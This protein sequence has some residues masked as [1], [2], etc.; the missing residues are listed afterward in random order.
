MP[1][2]CTH[3]FARLAENLE[4][5][6]LPSCSRYLATIID[7]KS[8]KCN[9]LKLIEQSEAYELSK[10]IFDL[11]GTKR[12]RFL[13][14]SG[15]SLLL[16][17]LVLLRLLVL[18]WTDNETVLM[19][20]GD[21]FRTNRDRKLVNY[22]CFIGIFL[23]NAIKI[24]LLFL[25]YSFKKPF[26]FVFTEYKD[27]LE[28]GRLYHLTL[29]DDQSF[30]RF[31]CTTLLTQKFTIE[32][33]YFGFFACHLSA[34]L[35]NSYNNLLSMGIDFFVFCIQFSVIRSPL[36]STFWFILKSFTVIT[37][38][39]YNLKSIIKKGEKREIET[40]FYQQI[41]C[42]NYMDKMNIQYDAVTVLIYTI[43]TYI[44]VL[45]F[46]HL[47]NYAET[48][49]YTSEILLTFGISVISMTICVLHFIG[50]LANKKT[51]QICIFTH[52]LARYRSLDLLA[53]LKKLEIL[54]RT[55]AMSAAF[56][57]NNQILL[58]NYLTLVYALECGSLYLLFCSNMNRN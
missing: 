38:V 23:L 10:W 36:L 40:F 50:S 4:R 25:N 9:L 54:D 15:I 24:F 6:R 35:F 20:L 3:C 52:K 29:E 47:T 42:Y 46:Y 44:V 37:F 21:Y 39:N 5:S 31:Y 49:T 33:V 28:N 12:K 56:K 58:N 1:C 27:Y 22:Y 43:V 55:A 26:T 16:N 34:I 7:T 51:Y 57:I 41:W 53:S 17:F 30:R 32:I 8:S 2:S 19:V 48:L 45:I 13:I 18:C 11:R 14:V